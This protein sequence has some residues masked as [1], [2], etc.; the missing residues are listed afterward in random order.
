MVTA[1]EWNS[2]NMQCYQCEKGM[3]A[4]SLGHHLADV[5]EIYQ[6]TVVAKDLLEDRP[7]MAYTAIAELHGRDLSC[8]FPGCEGRL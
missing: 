3:K 2:C 1:A 8:P 7:P 5:H 6:Q 4:C